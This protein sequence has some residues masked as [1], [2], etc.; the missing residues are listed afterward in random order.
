MNSGA[1]PPGRRSPAL[2]QSAGS[3]ES[4]TRLHG[5]VAYV[6][7]GP[8]DVAYPN[9]EDDF[10]RIT[11]VPVFKANLN[12]GHGGTY[13]QP[14]GGWFGE[15]AVRVAGLSAERQRRRREVVRRRRLPPVQGAGLDDR[16]ERDAVARWRV[17]ARAL[18]VA[19]VLAVAADVAAQTPQEIRLWPGKAPGSENWSV[20]ETT[21]TSPAGDRTIANVSDPSVTV[22]LPPAAHGHRC[23]R[24]RGARRRAAAARVGRRRR[25]G[26]AVVEQQGD[27]GARA[28]VPHAAGDAGDRSRRGAGAATGVRPA[29]ARRAARN[30]TS[31]R[32][33]PI[34]LRTT[35]R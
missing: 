23:G 24:R 29:R 18:I 3:K 11:K 1:F 4:L 19:A 6:I 21:T 32:P 33:T 31:R 8:T 25:Q 26:C 9:A 13:R 17:S 27:R 10:A 2:S 14:G 5:P 28:Q 35:P 20:P 7:G 22:Y 15:V 34:P 12:V 16:E 30:W